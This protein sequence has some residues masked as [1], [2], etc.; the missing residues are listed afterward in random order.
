MK[1]RSTT[2]ILLASVMMF[3]L[4]G[5]GNTSAETTETTETAEVEDDGERGDTNLKPADAS[6]EYNGKTM[7]FTDDAQTLI[8]ALD[9]IATK[10]GEGDV[11][12]ID[13]GKYYEYDKNSDNPNLTVIVMKVDGKDT[14]G[15]LSVENEGFKTSNGI[16]IGSTMEEVEAAYGNPS[17][18]TQ[19]SKKEKSDR[20]IY[21][22]YDIRFDIENGKVYSITYAHPEY[23]G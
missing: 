6:F 5:C 22:D 11:D 13:G 8:A 7:S 18:S 4:M 14:V 15:Y 12:G 10:S 23:K 20:Y 1:K 17:E 19:A 9:S 16:G 2:A 21:N 3:G